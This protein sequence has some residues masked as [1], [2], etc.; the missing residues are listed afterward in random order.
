MN[1]QPEASPVAAVQL[2]SGK[3]VTSSVNVSLL[4]ARTLAWRTRI[5]SLL[6]TLIFFKPSICSCVFHLNKH[7]LQLLLNFICFIDSRSHPG[8]FVVVDIKKGFE[9]CH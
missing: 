1:H 4:E 6:G 5:V 9:V 2:S 8:P 7:T 3:L